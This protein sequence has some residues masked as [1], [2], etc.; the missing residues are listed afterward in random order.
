MSFP[1][2]LLVDIFSRDKKPPAL[3]SLALVCR[4]WKELVYNEHS[5]WTTVHVT[6]H[7]TLG[8]VRTQLARSGDRHLDVELS[9][10]PTTEYGDFEDVLAAVFVERSRIE[11]LEIRALGECDDDDAELCW[12][13]AVEV[14]LCTGVAWPQLR[15]LDLDGEYVSDHTLE[16]D[17]FTPTLVQLQLSF[18][19]VREWAQLLRATQLCDLYL[20]KATSGDMYELMMVLPNCTNLRRLEL[21]DGGY[22]DETLVFSLPHGKP[23]VF[24]HL[25]EINVHWETVDISSLLRFL[26]CCPS[27][28]KLEVMAATIANLN[29]STSSPAFKLPRLVFLMLRMLPWG[30]DNTRPPCDFFNLLAPALAESK[31]REVDLADMSILSLA[32]LLGPHLEDLRLGSVVCDPRVLIPGLAR[33]TNLHTLELA[34]IEMPSLDGTWTSDVRLPS[35]RDAL[36]HGPDDDIRLRTA[37]TADRFAHNRRLAGFFIPLVESTGV[38]TVNILHVPLTVEEIQR[39]VKDLVNSSQWPL[40]VESHKTYTNTPGLKIR[41]EVPSL[42]TDEST[43]RTADREFEVSGLADAWRGLHSAYNIFWR[44]GSLSIDMGHLREF[45]EALLSVQYPE[46]PLLTRLTICAT[47][48]YARGQPEL[49]DRLE[50]VLDAVGDLC[51]AAGRDAVDTPRLLDVVFDNSAAREEGPLQVSDAAL[52]CFLALFKTPFEP[53]VTGRI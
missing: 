28:E 2:E 14:A 16:I 40:I 46:L 31:V 17:L 38:L 10:V 47:Y 27:V 30:R 15:V 4:Q 42:R 48:T 1:V 32:V 39:L 9:F 13:A 11:T 41:G 7:T 23:P 45:F 53:M 12:P 44:I 18:V 6:P 43:S 19:S 50:A 52:M 34:G 24:L 51:G 49:E 22:G 35:L 25:V 8:Q 37:P 20:N 3:E 5:L 26:A 29:V 36:L 33:C 21:N